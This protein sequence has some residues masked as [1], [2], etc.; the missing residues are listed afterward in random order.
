MCSKV[1]AAYAHLTRFFRAGFLRPA[2][3]GL[4]LKTVGEASDGG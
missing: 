3:D 4:T 1:D 2:L